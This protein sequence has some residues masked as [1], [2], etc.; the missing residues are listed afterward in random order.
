MTIKNQ[1]TTSLSSYKVE[2]NVAPGV[3][4]TNDYVP[5]GAVLS[6]LTGS[7][8]SARTISNHCVFTWANGPSIGAGASK[9]FNY[10][11]DSQEC[12]APTEVQPNPTSCVCVPETTAQF[13]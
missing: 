4:C 6:P 3:H 13:C 11:T 9:T 1:G 12:G 10:S 7:G 5:P 2:F 8:S